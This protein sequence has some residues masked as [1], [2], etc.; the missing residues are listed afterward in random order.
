MRFDGVV[1]EDAPDPRV[2]QTDQLRALP[3]PAIGLSPQ[4][5]VEETYAVLNS[6]QDQDGFFEMSATLSYLLWRNP[7]D[8]SDPSNLAELDDETR[9]S[10][11]DVPSW[12]R[13]QWLM[14]GVEKLKYPQLWEAVKTTWHRESSGLGSL[15]AVL[16]RHANHVLNNR[17]RTQRGLQN[18][19]WYEPLQ[20]SV[21]N[22]MVRTDIAVLVDGVEV[23]GI[24]FDTDPFVYGVG[25]G[26]PSG[27]VV[28]AVL[29]RD[30][31]EY[32]RVEF[33]TRTQPA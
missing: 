32:I 33:S 9:A 31:L 29:P 11:E 21:T 28:T 12:P 25:A 27:G 19:P 14:E 10:V 20:D 4:P 5:A 26:L 7:G 6:G 22:K 18:R 13:P 17:Y 8:R 23:L 2:A 1:P 15:S 24:E 16:V 3:V 30:E